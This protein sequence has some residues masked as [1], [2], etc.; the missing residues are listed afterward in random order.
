MLQKVDHCLQYD[1]PYTILE[2][3]QM[4]YVELKILQAYMVLNNVPLTMVQL[5][6]SSA[7]Y[8]RGICLPTGMNGVAVSP[9]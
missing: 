3:L 1:V 9:F 8:S 5:Y 6:L 7:G 4:K 2:R